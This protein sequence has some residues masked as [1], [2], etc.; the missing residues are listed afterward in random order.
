MQSSKI[1]RD[2]VSFDSPMECSIELLK[3]YGAHPRTNFRESFTPSPLLH[4]NCTN[5]KNSCCLDEEFEDFKDISRINLI[6][7]AHGFEEL[8]SAL[9]YLKHLNPVEIASFMK[10]FTDDQLEEL[11]MIKEEVT[12]ELNDLYNERDKI[13]EDLDNAFDMIEEF[14]AGLPCSICEA[15]N[16]SNFN[17]SADTGE[18]K[19]IFDFD[20]CYNLFESEVTK[21][22]MDFMKYMKDLNTF[23]I[24]LSTLYHVDM[25]DNL[26]EIESNIEI[27]DKLRNSC[28]ISK[29]DTSDDEECA[30]MCL[31]LGSPNRFFWTNFVSPLTTFG[32]LIKDYYGEREFLIN[33]SESVIKG[34][35]YYLNQKLDGVIDNIAHGWSVEYFLPPQDFEGAINL[36]KIGAELEYGTGWNYYN[37]RVKDWVVYDKSIAILSL[38]ALIPF[39]YLL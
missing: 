8:R 13:I 38:F 29:D 22:T 32:F 9:T 10:L 33:E 27:A 30:E 28:L 17:S 21:S 3:T 16:H 23:T 20:Y 24:L 26:S 25:Q 35:H 14:G 5:F 36:S 12:I 7:V 4:S 31:E 39:V 37:I 1:L 18:L 6:K 34:D 2:T 11:D 19:M 15:N